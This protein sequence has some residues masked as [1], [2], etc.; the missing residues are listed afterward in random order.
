MPINTDRTRLP[1]KSD[2][3]WLFFK[4]SGRVSR[5]AYVLGV[6]LVT[7]IQAFPLYH[8]KLVPEGTPESEMWWFISAIVYHGLALATSVLAGSGCTTSTS[9]ALPR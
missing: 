5:A 8:F 4:T 2:L 9:R 3:T 6:L 7:I 1:D